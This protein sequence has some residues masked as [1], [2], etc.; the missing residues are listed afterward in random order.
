MLAIPVAFLPFD[1][2]RDSKESDD[3]ESCSECGDEDDDDESHE[4]H[5][6][7]S[8]TNGDNNHEEKQTRHIGGGVLLVSEVLFSPK[9][10]KYHIFRV[11]QV[12]VFLL[13]C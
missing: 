6:L 5:L 2:N 1:P 7:N 4:D 13:Q 12:N 8:V 10:T 11:Q 3:D 9:N